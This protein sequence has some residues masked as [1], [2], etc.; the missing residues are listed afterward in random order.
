MTN[1]CGECKECCRACNIKEIN[2][3]SGVLCWLYQEGQGCSIHDTKPND[4][5][6]YQCVWITQKNIDVK[7]RP[8]KLGVIFE[9]PYNC[10]FWMGIEL[11]DGAL[12]KEDTAQLVRAMNNDGAAVVLKSTNGAIQYSLPKGMTFEQLNE[13]YSVGMRTIHKKDHE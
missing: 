7:Y 12:A 5:K 8:D 2:K 4:C 6:T 9:Q 11:Q 10:S 3:P 13:M 1:P